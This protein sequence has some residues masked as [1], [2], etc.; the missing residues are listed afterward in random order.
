MNYGL[1]ETGVALGYLNRE[2][3]TKEKFISNPFGD[4]IVYKTGDLCVFLPDGCINYIGRIDNQIK[5]RGLRIELGEI[6]AKILEFSGIKESITTINSGII[7]SYIVTKQ[8]VS[9]SDLKKYLGKALPE[10]MVPS[11][12]TVIDSIPLNVSGKVDRKALPI[13]TFDNENREIIPARNDIDKAIISELKTIL[14]IEKI[15]IED[16]FFGIGGDSLNAITLCS[17]LSD[18]LNVQVSV[19]D[20]FENPI[21]S[22][23]SDV[24]SN[25]P[26]SAKDIAVIQKCKALPF[27]PLSSAQKRIYYAHSLSGNK[28]VVYN[29]SGGIL[30][31][32]KL[33]SKKVQN[34]LNELIKL[35]SSF[36]TRFK[37]ENN[38]LVQEI[39]TEVSI[40]LETEYS[41]L[42]A[43]VLVDKF[44]KPFDLSKA[45]LL[46]AKLV[47]LEDNS[48]LILLDTHH[49]VVDG[50][51]LALVFNDFCALYNG[52]TLLKSDL[53]YV[54]YSIW[55]ENFLQ[56]DDVKVFEDFWVNKFKGQDFTAL[57][58]PYDYPLSSVKSYNGDKV[59]ISLSKDE[60]SALEN[61]ARKHNVSSYSVF[62]AG[63]YVLL[64]KYTS[65]NEIIVGSPF[66][67]RSFGELQNIV[68]YV[69]K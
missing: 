8:E 57:N 51:S 19:K 17:H 30:F 64:Y 5:L 59:S 49:I 12:I 33:D 3:L 55:E 42:D 61:I 13:P 24:I 47:Y 52:K 50:S 23:L 25:S 63:L 41:S 40:P 65:Q 22:H 28:N 58:L 21:I 36:R 2:D 56:S 15:S 38:G 1:E 35:H 69:C 68:R 7:C 37:Y 54:D 4:G 32:E 44:V 14:N 60:F 9:I 6:D 11:F 27:Y 48:S 62:L 53:E 18:K 66:A 31:N 10:F 16:S 43:Q 34:A 45:P 67:G 46:R 29:V 20:V 39:L 26:T